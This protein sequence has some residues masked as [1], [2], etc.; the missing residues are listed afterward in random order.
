MESLQ[1]LPKKKDRLLSPIEAPS[2]KSSVDSTSQPMIIS[3]PF[4]H[5]ALRLREELNFLRPIPSDYIE[6]DEH[7][8]RK[9]EREEAD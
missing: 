8:D 1:N 3:K 7:V 4:Q 2:N 5:K 6:T 9:S